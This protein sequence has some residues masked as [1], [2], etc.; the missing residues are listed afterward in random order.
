MLEKK[1]TSVVRLQKRVMELEVKLKEAEREYMQGAPT[2]ENRQPGEWI[3]RP[4][5]K[6][7]LTGHR[8]PITRVIFH[9]VFTLI[10]SSSEDSTIKAS[11]PYTLFQS[12]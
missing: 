6:F 4:P 5:E 8:S 2:R 10:A 11:S 7:C 9:P 3:P 1:W 12:L